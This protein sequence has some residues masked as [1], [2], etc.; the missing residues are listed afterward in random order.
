MK[1]ILFECK[2]ANAQA[3]AQATDSNGEKNTYKY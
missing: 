1:K 2:N 3:Q